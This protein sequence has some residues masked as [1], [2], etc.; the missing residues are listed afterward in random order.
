MSRPAFEAGNTI[1][2][3][4]T[5]SVAPDAAPRFRVVDAAE[6]MVTSLTAVSSDTTHYYAI[7]TMP[8][9]E[10]AYIGEWLAAKT[11]Q[12]SA[13]NFLKKFAFNVITTKAS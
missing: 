2:F 3:T 5:T 1:Q 10:G 13:R 6:A 4:L 11:F 9:G 7:V 12:G 8:I